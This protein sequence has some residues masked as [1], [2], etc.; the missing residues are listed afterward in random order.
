M[1]KM[2][3]GKSGRF[4]DLRGKIGKRRSPKMVKPVGS[5]GGALIGDITLHGV[6]NM[7]KRVTTVNQ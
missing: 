6:L 5:S 2:V 3:N 1:V 4:G 7:V